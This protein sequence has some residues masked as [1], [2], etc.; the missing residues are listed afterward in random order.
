MGLYS[1]W[2][3]CVVINPNWI[4]VCNHEGGGPGTSVVVNGTTYIVAAIYYSGSYDLNLARITKQD[5]SN[6]NL[7]VYADMSLDNSSLVGKQVVIGGFGYV[8][9]ALTANGG[10]YNWTSVGAGTLLWG[11]NTVTYNMYNYLYDSFDPSGSSKATPYEAGLACGD[12]GGGWFYLNAST[13]RWTVAALNDGVT[14]N[15]ACMFNPSDTDDAVG[16]P[17]VAAWANGIISAWAT[18]GTLTVTAASSSSWVYQNTP[19]ATLDRHAL[20]LAVN[21]TKDTWNN[22]NYTVTVTQTGPGVVTPT[23][24]WTR[25][26][27][28]APALTATWT[29]S[30]GSSLNGY[31]VGGRVQGGGIVEGDANLAVTGDCTVTVTVVGDVSGPQNQA[32]ATVPIVVSPLGDIDGDGSVT[33]IDKVLMNAKLHGLTLAAA[34]GFDAEAWD[35]DG[36]GGAVS[37]TDMTILNLVLNGGLVN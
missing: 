8:R 9:G 21:V 12:S 27:T 31:L 10:G 23:P 29:V 24:T 13:G 32:T 7:P 30:A 3:G 28:V 34:A 15:G 6:A 35:L 22:H 26:T 37:Q 2:M 1:G 36:S 18:Q 14:T 5:G 11:T 25:G 17:G 33:M 4:I 19:L 16:V 20:T